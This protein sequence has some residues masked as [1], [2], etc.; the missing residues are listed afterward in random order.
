MKKPFITTSKIVSLVF[1]IFIG[2]FFLPTQ[3]HAQECE[4]IQCNTDDTNAYYQCNQEKQK[5]LEQ[6]IA[7]TQASST[8]LKN[9]IAILNGQISLQQLQ[10]NQTLVEIDQLEKEVDELTE[11]IGGL[12]LSLDR[13]SA[14]LIERIRANYKQSRFP[15]ELSLLNSKSFSQ[16]FT[17]FK[18]LS[19]AQKQTANAMQRTESQRQLYDE[20]KILKEEKQAEV[21]E[22]KQSL[23]AE[24]LKLDSQKVEKQNLLDATQND[25][26]RYQQ[27]LDDARKELSQIVSA[28]KTII[29][30]GNGVQ[31]KKGE[32][33]GTMGNSG[34]SSGAHLHFGVYRYSSDEFAGDSWNWY[35]SNYVNPLERLGS[36]SILWD[37]GCGNDPSGTQNS[38]NGSW[39]WPMSNI[40]VTQNYGSNTCYNWLYGGK[41]HPA[42]DLVGSGDISVRAVDDG[43]AYFCRNC[44]GDGGNGVFVFHDD[45]YMTLYWHLK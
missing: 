3:I 13:L 21:E 38:G 31:V 33:I 39:D 7:E 26:K 28:A 23:V 45:R 22:K 20:Q 16:F 18:Y 2:S 24:R 19:L 17:Q 37:T 25:E 12:S 8:T 42:L 11:R 36:K 15:I 35:Y 27:L 9:T 40:R 41:P 1:S 34:Y 5:C 4:D 30:E 44:L 10:I 29:R 6:K 14:I 32:V 43:E